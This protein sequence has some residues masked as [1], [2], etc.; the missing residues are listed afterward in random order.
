MTD[1]AKTLVAK[2]GFDPAY[3]ARP[4]RRYLQNHVEDMAAQML[5]D[6]K[7]NGQKLIVDAI[8]GKIILRTE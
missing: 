3:G 6:G 5:L 2:E 1:Q 4:I 8:E 7:L